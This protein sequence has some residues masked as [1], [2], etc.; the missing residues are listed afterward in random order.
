[1]GQMEAHLAGSALGP[2]LSWTLSVSLPP[3]GADLK[4]SAWQTRGV[5]GLTWGQ[6]SRPVL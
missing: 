3:T 1:M 5:Y 4:S 2:P 6:C